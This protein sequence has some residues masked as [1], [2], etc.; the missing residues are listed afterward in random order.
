MS[1][2]K[3]IA[4]SAP[5]GSQGGGLVR[6]I[7]ADPIGGFAARAITRDTSKDKAKALASQGAEVVAGRP[8][9]RREPEE[10]VRGRARRLRRHQLL[11]ALLRREGKGAGEEHRRGRQGRRRQARHLVD[12]RRHAPVHGGRRQAHADAAGK[13][14]RAALRRQ[15][16]SGRASSP[17][18]PTT[19]LVDVV[20][21]GQPLH[22]RP[23]AEEGRG[24]QLQLDV[25][26]GRREAAGIAAEDIG[27][28]AYGI[29]KAGQ[30]YI[31]KTVGINGESADHRT[32]WARSSSRVSASAR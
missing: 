7:L 16:R 8:R 26:D 6:A 14:S 18:V 24:R 3:I 12:A 22:V 15:G 21:L 9:R 2:K 23:G 20:L 1:D 27:K 32:R 17:G 5:T 25:P 30:Q 4:V 31:G 11:G 10:G 13:V 28:V 19:F 29:F